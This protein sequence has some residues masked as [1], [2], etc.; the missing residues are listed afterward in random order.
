MLLVDTSVW[1]DWLGQRKRPGAALLDAMLDTEL[2]GLPAVV[3]QEL[4]QG[5]S[6]PERAARIEG[7]FSRLAVLLHDDADFDRI[8]RI[9]PGLKLLRG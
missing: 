4:L 9:A 8:G 3:L 2:I 7:Y 6:D 5:A 1:I